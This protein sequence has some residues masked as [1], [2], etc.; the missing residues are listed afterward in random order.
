MLLESGDPGG[1]PKASSL[2]AED[3]MRRAEVDHQLQAAV[4]E[5]GFSEWSQS[6]L[7]L[8]I[9]FDGRGHRFGRARST[10]APPSWPGFE[11]SFS[12][13]SGHQFVRCGAPTQGSGQWIGP[14]TNRFLSVCNDHEFPLSK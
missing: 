7:D 12:D 9:L 14:D 2:F 13:G 11:F 1:L 8:P 6:P 10:K 5:D 3:P 4:G